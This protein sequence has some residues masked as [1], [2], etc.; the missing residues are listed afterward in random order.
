MSG[1][2]GPRGARGGLGLPRG[3]RGSCWGP[4]WAGP[5]LRYHFFFF[6]L[7]RNFFR[8]ASRALDYFFGRAPRALSLL[9]VT[10]G[11]DQRRSSLCM[12]TPAPHRL[13]RKAS[14]LHGVDSS[15]AAGISLPV[16]F[17]ITESITSC[18]EWEEEYFSRES[19]TSADTILNIICMSRRGG[20]Y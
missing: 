16:P 19:P 9:W 4:V 3:P 17:S 12:P 1:A 10:L 2:R 5:V 11:S 15:H 14:D 18:S 8:R 20:P 7:K 13:S 6:L